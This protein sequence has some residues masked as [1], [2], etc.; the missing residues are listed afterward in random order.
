M[1][2]EDAVLY[3][4]SSGF[5]AASVEP[6]D[7]FDEPVVIMG[8]NNNKESNIGFDIYR[9]GDLWGVRLHTNYQNAPH[10]IIESL[11]EAVDAVRGFLSGKTDLEDSSLT[12]AQ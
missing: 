12:V 9:S 5:R 8:D 4:R 2:P 11:E 10:V 3:L 7:F 1:T 6:D